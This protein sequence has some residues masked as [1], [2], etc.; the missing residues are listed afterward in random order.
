MTQNQSTDIFS[1]ERIG[2]YIYLDLGDFLNSE[3]I[4]E[5][6]FLLEKKYSRFKVLNKKPE[7][8]IDDGGA[9][10]IIDSIFLKKK[11]IFNKKKVKIKKK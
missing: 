1:L 3:K 7:I 8:K 5:L 6:I 9:K 4:S 10:R 11:N 2:H